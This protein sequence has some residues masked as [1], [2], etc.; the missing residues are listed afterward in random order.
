MSA[1]VAIP[2]PL[3]ALG[4]PCVPGVQAKAQAN[5]EAALKPAPAEAQ[6]LTPA[7]AAATADEFL[8]DKAQQGNRDAL[9]AL[10]ARYEKSL[11]GLLLRM[12]KGDRNLADDLFQETFL[13]AIRAS[14]TFDRKK[15]FKPWLTAIAVNLVRDDARKRKVRSE[16][17][18][19][20]CCDSQFGPR[21]VSGRWSLGNPEPVAAGENPDESAQRRDDEDYIQR[22]L[23]DLTDLEREVVLLHF[24]NGMTLHETAESLGVPIGTAK[25]RLHAALMRLSELL[26]PWTT[27]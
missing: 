3:L 13:H 5:A 10:I 16:V 26:T 19:D 9:G 27:A 12:C 7:D 1:A 17:A 23:G 8:F 4:A 22:A 14:G 25:S 15:R 18:L 24:Y 21:P 6:V 11:F 2:S 20:T